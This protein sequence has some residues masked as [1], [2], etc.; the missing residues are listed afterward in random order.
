MKQYHTNGTTHDATVQSEDCNY[1]DDKCKVYVKEPW[2]PVNITRINDVFKK[3]SMDL[4]TFEE[5][6]RI[7]RQIAEITSKYNSQ[8]GLLITFKS[9][10]EWI[11]T[12][13]GMKP[14]ELMQEL[15]R[16]D[17]PTRKRIQKALHS[18]KWD[19]L[20]MIDFGNNSTG[21]DMAENE[22]FLIIYGN[23]ISGEHNKFNGYLY[24]DK[25]A[26]GLKVAKNHSKR[27]KKELQILMMSEYFEYP[28]RSRR[29]IPTYCITNYF[30]EEDEIAKKTNV[31]I[32]ED[33]NLEV[34][35]L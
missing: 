21:T 10:E 26:H 31:E 33:Y 16:F 2:S 30:G 29:K 12:V 8:H 6:L 24:P 18:T 11:K 1:P 20:R 4:N 13:R 23:W 32:L 14:E 25:Q 19:Y 15:I 5:F 22:K 17:E 7:D 27:V 34:V 28:L 9:L 35:F 3:D